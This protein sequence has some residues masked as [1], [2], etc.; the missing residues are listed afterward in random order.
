[1]SE[2]ESCGPMLWTADGGPALSRVLKQ[3][4]FKPRKPPAVVSDTDR[5]VIIITITITITITILSESRSKSGDTAIAQVTPLR[6]SPGSG[7]GP[8]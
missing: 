7:G 3:A 6:G 2:I 1:M 8:A 4:H 5:A